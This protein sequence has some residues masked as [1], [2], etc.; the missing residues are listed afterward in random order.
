MSAAPSASNTAGQV[1][2][3]RRRFMRTFEGERTNEHIRVNRGPA[4]RS[5]ARH[6][7][8]SCGSGSVEQL[9][10]ALLVNRP[11]RALSSEPVSRELKRAC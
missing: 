10:V 9:S 8:S 7:G 2:R 11:V 6:L 3:I 5:A 4:S 1:L